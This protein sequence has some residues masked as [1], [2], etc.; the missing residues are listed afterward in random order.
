MVRHLAP[1]TEDVSPWRVPLPP[2]GE[3]IEFLKRGRKFQSRWQQGVFLGVKDN[4]IKKIVGSASGVFTMQSTRRKPGEEWHNPE[5]P[6]PVGFRAS[7][8]QGR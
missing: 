6:Q 1:G 4:G 7:C 8:Y 2:F 3:T 5:L